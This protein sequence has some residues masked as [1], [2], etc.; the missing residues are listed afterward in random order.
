MEKITEAQIRGYL[1]D[2]EAKFHVFDTVG[3]TNTEAKTLARD[4]AQEGDT[5]VSSFQTAGRGRLTRS[6]FSP[7]ETGLYMSIVLRPKITLPT[8]I[9]TAAA[10]AVCVALEKLFGVSPKIKWVND[11][12]L[13]G[14]K[15]CGILTE[16][17]AEPEKGTLSYAVLGIGINLYPPKDGFPPELTDIAGYVTDTVEEG[18]KS[19]L[20]AS[21]WQE[22]FKIYENID[23]REF[24]AEYRERSLVLQS[25]REVRVIMGDE[26]KNAYVEE[27]DGDCSLLLRFEDGTKRK[28]SSGEI[29]IKL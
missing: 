12:F 17:A 11:I 13:H 10:V 27:I 7:D 19:R 23:S 14:K 5:V 28:M 20:C 2:S 16:A 18:M 8:L 21:V 29:S 3:S 25:N 22:F 6:F 1:P 4:G 9:T 15:V 26:A 24:L